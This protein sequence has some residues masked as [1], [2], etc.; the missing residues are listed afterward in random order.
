MERKTETGGHK[1]TEELDLSFGPRYCSKCDFEAEDGYQLDGH[2]WS[3]HD[4]SDIN[5]FPC[6]HCDQTFSTLKDLMSHKKKMHVEN[7]S[8]CWHFSKS[9]CIF[10]DENCWFVHKD[11]SKESDETDKI[12]MKCNICDKILKTKKEFMVHRKKE[13]EENIQTCNLYKKGTC[14]YNESCWFSHKD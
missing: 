12:S 10:G 6:S 3:E 13:H 9:S 1:N 8:T 2:F 14:T 5:S 11:Q 4:D 7:V